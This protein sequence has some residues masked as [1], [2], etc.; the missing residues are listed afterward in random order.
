MKNNGFS[1]LNTVISQL[2]EVLA[3]TFGEI[4]EHTMFGIVESTFA[5]Q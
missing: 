1:M 5:V 4:I 3:F 2:P